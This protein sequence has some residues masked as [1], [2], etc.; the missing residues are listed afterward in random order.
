MNRRELAAALR[1]RPWSVA[2]LA[3]YFGAGVSEIVEDLRR[4]SRSLKHG[5][6]ALQVEPGLCRKCGFQF[7]P[8][9]LNKPSRCPQCKGSWIRDPRVSIRRS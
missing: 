4:L 7:A 2:E 3:R 6:E 9:K 5:D 1:E 8:E